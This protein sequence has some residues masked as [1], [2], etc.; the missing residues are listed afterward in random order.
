MTVEKGSFGDPVRFITRFASAP[1]FR[2]PGLAVSI[3]YLTAEPV[4]GMPAVSA[5]L[6][7][8]LASGNAED[9]KAGTDA[10]RRTVAAVHALDDF[11]IMTVGR[12]AAPSFDPLIKALDKGLRVIDGAISPASSESAV[13][14]VEAA[15]TMNL[16]ASAA[17]HR[18]GPAISGEIQSLDDVRRSL[19]KIRDYYAANEPASP[20]PLLLL[21]AERLVGKGFLDLLKNLTP[22][23]RSEFD[24]HLGPQPEENQ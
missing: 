15:T 8:I 1:I 14:P 19:A 24:V 12:E 21:R 20:V 4:P 23:S 7:E 11:L 13:A 9:I 22:N 5:R 2:V 6:P 18:A 17:P 10:L 16:A 3:D